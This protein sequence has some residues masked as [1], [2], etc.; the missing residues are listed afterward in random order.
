M[1]RFSNTDCGRSKRNTSAALDFVWMRTDLVWRTLRTL[2]MKIAVAAARGRW[3]C[4]LAPADD[5]PRIL[6]CRG[7]G[8][9]DSFGVHMCDVQV[10]VQKSG[11]FN[12]KVNQSE[13][14]L[15]TSGFC[16]SSSS[17]IK[18]SPE[19]ESS[20]LAGGFPREGS[21][22]SLRRTSVDS[23]A[24]DLRCRDCETETV[25]AIFIPY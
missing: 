2:G 3:A 13:Q 25:H 17:R 22:G 19:V 20:A 4:G 14:V 21:Q 7:T 24:V 11:V 10:L 1:V 12:C 5:G 6:A 15:L 16:Q 18:K 8:G 9:L 23:T